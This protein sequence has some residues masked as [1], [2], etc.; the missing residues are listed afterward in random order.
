VASPI[1][2]VT[3][4]GPVRHHPMPCVVP[5]HQIRRDVRFGLSR[6]LGG[7]YIEALRGGSVELSTREGPEA[8]IHPAERSLG[9]EGGPRERSRNL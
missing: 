8:G 1:P 6:P 4:V 3:V 2:P 9:L 5:A 7:A